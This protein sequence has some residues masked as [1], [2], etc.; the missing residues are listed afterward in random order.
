MK[1]P[2]IS[3]K[4]SLSTLS[5]YSFDKTNIVYELEAYALMLDKLNSELEKMLKECF[6]DT[7]DSYGL[8]NRE[9]IIGVKRDD[10]TISK[11]REMLKLRESIDQSSFTVDKIKKSLSSFGLVDYTLKE[12]PYLYTVVIDTLGSY[13]EPQKAWI[14]SQVEKIM[15]A[16]LNAYVVF[17]GPTWQ[18]SDTKNNS[19]SYIDSLD[20]K[21]EEIDNLE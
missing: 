11:R 21:W 14:R 20:Y 19:F 18:Q 5:L 7:A 2:Y 4:E 12:F 9:L 17:N 10:L 3:M 15:P 13:T 1:D 6:I 16:H 8:E